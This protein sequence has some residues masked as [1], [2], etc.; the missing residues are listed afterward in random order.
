MKK[1]RNVDLMVTVPCQFCG[2][3][4][5]RAVRTTLAVKSAFTCFACGRARRREASARYRD[6]KARKVV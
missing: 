3:G 2:A 4:V 1:P 5:S 6:R